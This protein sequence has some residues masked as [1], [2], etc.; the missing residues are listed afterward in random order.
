MKLLSIL[1]ALLSFASTCL[2]SEENE[3]RSL[4]DAFKAAEKSQD[5]KNQVTMFLPEELKSLKQAALSSYDRAKEKMEAD[6]KVFSVAFST[7][8]GRIEIENLTPEEVFIAIRQTTAMPI[9]MAEKMP[10]MRFS[11]TRSENGKVFIETVTAMP[12][13]DRE[14]TFDLEVIEAEGRRYLRVPGLLQ[15][16]IDDG[17]SPKKQG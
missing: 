9:D 4:F 2:C 10:E 5:W 1:I 11:K 8:K 6:G 12:G 3:Y 7:F 13:T 17:S 14:V 16:I 15:M